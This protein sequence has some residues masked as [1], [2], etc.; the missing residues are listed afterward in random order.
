MNITL[1]K[2][3]FLLCFLC[4]AGNALAQSHVTSANDLYT[5]ETIA[6]EGVDYLAVG[7]SS[8]FEDYA[9]N[10]PSPDGE[11]MIG[12]TLI[13]GVFK[14]YDFP[15]AKNTYF[16][17]LGNNGVAGGYYEDSDGLHHG[18]IV[19]NGEMKRYDFPGAVETFIFGY[20]DSKGYSLAVL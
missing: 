14:T 12:F 16:Y 20:S 1:R 5:F 19:E 8:D 4:F 3:S 9:G 18:I 7:A 2:L 17:A 6:V 13:D 11:R 10:T 15:G